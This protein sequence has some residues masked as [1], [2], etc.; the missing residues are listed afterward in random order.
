[1]RI[2]ARYA[3]FMG[4]WPAPVA[5]VLRAQ[6]PVPLPAVIRD[7]RYEVRFDSAA[8]RRHRIGVA[9]SFRTENPG[10][11]LLSLPAWTPGAYELSYF[12][13]NVEHFAVTGADGRPLAWD[14]VDF[15]TWRIRAEDRR[16]ITVTFE[17]VADSLDNAMAWSRPDFGMY[18]GTNLFLY[19][20][21]QSLDFPAQ[22]RIRTESGWQIATGLSAAGPPGEYTAASYHQLVD[23]PVFVG[24]LEMDSLEIG[25]AWYRLATYPAGTLSGASRSR[26]WDHLRRVMPPLIAVTGE[27]PWSAYTVLM[28]FEPGYAGA[29]ALEHENSHVG[30]YHPGLLFAG[31]LLVSITAH[32][33]FHAWN[34]KRLRPAELWP[35]DYSRAQPTTLLWVSEGITD[36]YAD[37]ALVRGGVITPEQFYRVTA[38]KM[39]QVAA[40]PATALEDASLTTWIHPVDGSQYLYYPKGSLAG[41][42][43]DILI[44]DAS[45]NRSSLDAVMRDL[46]QRFYRAGKGFTVAD[47]WEAVERA[48]GGRS[49]AEFYRRYVDGREP[50]P[51]AAVLPLAG[52]ALRADTSRVPRLGVNTGADSSGIRV[53]EVTPGSPAEQA[54]IQEGDYLLRVGGVEVRDA[55]FGEL[56]RSRYATAPEGT[57]LAV[58]V[59][60]GTETLT[61]SAPLRFE[62][63]VRYSLAADP[64]AGSKAARIREGILRGSVSP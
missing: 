52:L 61:L 26:F 49:F 17:Y 47:W 42:L 13:R 22:V 23:M 27:T 41:W 38:D 30:V 10:P 28:L 9:M 4:L 57:P 60:R 34:V 43:L 62:E 63:S 7:V 50:F 11:V 54:G 3:A 15:D 29:S 53:Q 8:A 44:R 58:T 1:M 45:D 19:P 20:E 32:E 33:I 64:A 40:A 24:R 16:P 18:N 55:A 39:T 56:F 36:Y 48:A 25:G 14:K 12:A 5:Q 51:Y 21:G 35:Y 31:P 37:L 6:T 59:R 46:Y 2:A